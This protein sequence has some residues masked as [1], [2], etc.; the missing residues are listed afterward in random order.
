LIA[1][2]LAACE[3]SRA[4]VLILGDSLTGQFGPP[5][6]EQSW[7]ETRVL[8][9]YWPGTNPVATSWLSWL[10][11]VGGHLDAVVLEDYTGAC[12][13]MGGFDTGSYTMAVQAIV[14]AAHARGARFIFLGTAEHP[15][16]GAVGGIDAR[17]R[18][19][20]ADESDGVHYSA[21]RATDE[22]TLLHEQLGLR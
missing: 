15:D 19:A 1:L 2:L 10:N 21:A 18:M 6:S 17:F 7:P 5:L 22:A 12:C 11:N 8:I 16:L 4:R 3:P 20:P 14:D 9:R 13:D